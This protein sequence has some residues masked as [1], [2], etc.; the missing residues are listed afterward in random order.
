MADDQNKQPA[1]D[2]EQNNDKQEAQEKKARRKFVL[3][4]ERSPELDPNSPEFDPVK[5]E[6]ATAAA[7]EQMQQKMAEYSQ[8]IAN[9]IEAS[10]DPDLIGNMLQTVQ[11]TINSTIDTTREFLELVKG[12]DTAATQG[13]F[14]NL[15][16]IAESA[17]AINKWMAE[18]GPLQKY[19]EAELQ[20]PE[21]AA[22]TVDDLI[23]YGRKDKDG[24]PIDPTGLL[25]KAVENA[26]AAYQEDLKKLPAST[27]KRA[28]IVHYPLDKVNSKIWNLLKED[29]QGQL[30][31]A[32]ENKTDKRKGRNIDLLYSIDFNDLGKDITIT[33]RLL[34][35]DKRVYIAVSALF[36]AGNTTIALTQ[37]YYAMGY[38][39]RPG[40][41][42]LEKINNSITKMMGAKIYVNNT[43]EANQYNYPK[44]VYDG[45]LLPIERVSAVHNGQLVDAAINIFREP[46]VI[47]FARQRNQI[48]TI[49]VKMLQS[50]VSKTD[51]NLQIEDYLIERIAQAKNGSGQ[52]RIL[53][54]T[55]YAHIGLENETKT[56]QKNIKKRT[57]G[58]VEKYLK[59]YQKCGWI[60]RYTMETDGITVYFS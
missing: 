23:E 10:L 45:A 9:A 20:K 32:M 51:A 57:P 15:V 60:S 41:N 48:T 2:A 16:Y 6:A 37:I 5:Y 25:N 39:G 17:E 38:T 21:Y 34:P 19:L 28:D 8:V 12:F 7:N 47:T 3:N 49:A 59:Y 56:N 52:R 22:I 14:N 29:T 58:K 50:P 36:N 31:F 30:T 13:I 42:D 26:R 35:F 11:D 33:K 53:Y 43:D 18:L 46:P 44:F 1:H 24:N 4:T 40:T 54:K 27:V 55:L